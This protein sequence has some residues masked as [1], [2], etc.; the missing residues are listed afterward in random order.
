MTSRTRRPALAPAAA[1]SLLIALGAP[2]GSAFAAVEADPI[3]NGA[4]PAVHPL[5]AIE[6]SPVAK[7]AAE[8]EQVR[9]LAEEKAALLEAQAAAA[10]VDKRLDYDPALIAA[11]GN[12][13][14]SGHWICCPGF[15]C[16][17]GDAILTGQVNDHARYGCGCCTWPGWGGGNSSFRSLGTDAALLREAYDEI[18]AGRPTVIHVMGAFNEHWIC[19]MGYQGAQDPDNLALD[20][21]IALDPVDGA[22]IV[23]SD[24]YALYGDAC[25]HVSDLR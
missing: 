16:A 15:A 18:A 9:A 23:A 1:L 11:V 17:Y 3:I 8:L 12:Q 14:T 6:E 5:A 19:L 4:A 21:F 2:A 13:E 20:N 24:R 10:R 7:A 25:E 22:E